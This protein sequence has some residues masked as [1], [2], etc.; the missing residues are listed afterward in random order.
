MKL[1]AIDPGYERLGIA[2]I[3][4]PS[5]SGPFDAAQGKEVLLFSECFKTS[6]KDAHHLRLHQLAERLEYI[7]K[8]FAPEALALETLFFSKNT[9]TALKVSEARGVIIERATAFGLTVT[10]FSPQEIKI[11]VT[12]A[13]NSDKTQVM[14]MVPLLI[15]VS[16]VKKQDD[17]YDAIACGLTFFATQNIRNILES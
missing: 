10:E 14:K 16:G 8:Q 2:V 5:G 4:K 3:E 9:K 15:N 7:I 6:A 17:E 12:G 11:A 1:L 13:G